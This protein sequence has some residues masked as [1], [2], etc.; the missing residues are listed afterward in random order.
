MTGYRE[1]IV[2]IPIFGLATTLKKFEQRMTRD[3]LKGLGKCP[4]ILPEA[5]G[6]AIREEFFD[7]RVSAPPNWNG[8]DKQAAPFC[9]QSGQTA[10]VVR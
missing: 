3:P 1:V 10:A 2:W 9:S 6:I 8:A 7:L 5:L 4:Q